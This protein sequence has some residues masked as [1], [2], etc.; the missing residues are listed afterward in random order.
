[1]K[2]E[3][4]TIMAILTIAH[5]T[6]AEETKPKR[7]GRVYPPD[8]KGAKVEVYKTI[9]DV[10][11]NM[12]IF[13]PANHKPSDKVPAIV[14]FFGGGW[15]SGTPQQFEQHCR[16]LASRGMVAMTADYRVSSRHE[17]KAVVCVADAKSAVR[18]VR[19]NANRLGVDP[20]RVAAGGG[21]AGGHIAACTG[22]VK[23][24]DDSTEDSSIS[25]VP[26]AMVLFNPALVLSAIEGKQPLDEKRM[27]G[28][29]ERTGVDPIEISP[30]HH[31]SKGAPPTIIFHG[32]A[33][34][35]VPYWTTEKFAAAMTKAGNNCELYGFEDQEHGFFNYGRGDNKMFNATTKK[36][37]EFLVQLGYLNKN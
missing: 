8:L 34:A 13:T 29:P 31:V 35:T 1:M 27:A 3:T 20:D 9:G 32:I 33:D 36:M 4:L 25:S 24:F 22:V 19:A 28:L 15:R 6:V 21:S 23:Q 12:Y 37:D 17:T 10:K 2:I 16:L 26:N 5:L 7:Q 11:L 18:W 30:Y 14:F